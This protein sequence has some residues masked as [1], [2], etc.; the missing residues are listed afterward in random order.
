MSALSLSL[1]TLQA[2]PRG[3][4][5]DS[6]PGIDSLRHEVSNQ[7]TE[8]RMLS[9]RLNTQEALIDSLRTDVTKSAKES[10]EAAK[11][12]AN[13]TQARLADLESKTVSLTAEVAQLQK[14]ST[15]MADLLETYRELL[16]KYQR[17]I[18][19]LEASVD[20]QTKNSRHLEKSLGTILEAVGDDTPADTSGPTTTYKV[21]PGDNLEKIARR[22]KT[23][24]RALKE[25][26]GLNNDRIIVGQKLKV[27]QTPS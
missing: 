22:Y 11:G 4:Y 2:L 19:G 5:G 15:A 25:L 27:P 10:Q 13:T 21:V 14:H 16:T 20:Q 8:L 3:S 9:E 6:G 24:I 1:S 7:E 17:K 18:D 12:N 26:N 23:T